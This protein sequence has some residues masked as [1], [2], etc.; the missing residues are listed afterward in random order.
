MNK[1]TETRI[2]KMLRN[3]YELDHVRTLGIG[4]G[5]ATEYSAVFEDA[6]SWA[7]VRLSGFR[8]LEELQKIV[9]RGF[10]IM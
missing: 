8:D 6:N 7:F 1:R 3:G 5:N 10:A 4:Y 2:K 9:G